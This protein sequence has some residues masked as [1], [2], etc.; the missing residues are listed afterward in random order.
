[1]SELL[2]KFL[3]MWG[4]KHN[5]EKEY[6]KKTRHLQQNKRE[7]LFLK[8]FVKYKLL[9]AVAY[10]RMEKLKLLKSYAPTNV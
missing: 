5:I 1:M 8:W 4:S 10:E 6:A 2:V 3:K 7:S 9:A